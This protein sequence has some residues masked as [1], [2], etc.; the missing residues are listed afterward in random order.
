[1]ARL[2]AW[3]LQREPEVRRLTILN[4]AG[5]GEPMT[6]ARC[7]EMAHAKLM[8]VPGRWAMRIVLQILWKRGISAIPPEAVPYMSG[9]YIMNTD[10]LKKFLGEDYEKV[11]RFSIAD[12]FA[13]SFKAPAPVSEP[14][15]LA[16]P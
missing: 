9:Q 6:F 4:V 7:I 1:M 10:R 11:I 14:Q 12:A 15:N 16:V 2:I 8:R 5:R 13:D 3:I